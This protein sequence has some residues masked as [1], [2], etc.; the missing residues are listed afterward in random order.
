MKFKVVIPAR[1]ASQRLPGKPLLAIAGRPMIHWVWEA[2]M[3]SGADEVVVA[4]DDQRIM[5]A[6][7]AFGGQALMTSPD[8]PSGTD[9]ISEVIELM[10]WPDDTIVVN[11]Q[12]DEPEMPTDNVF[13]VAELLHHATDAVMAS[14][15][16]PIDAEEDWRNPN[17]VKVVCTQHQRALYFSRAP[18]PWHRDANGFGHSV[19]VAGR[20][21]GLYAYR[22][23][24]VRQYVRLP[25]TPLE[26]LEKLEQLRVLEHGYAIAM[27]PCRKAPPAGVDTE[28]DLHD[29]RQRLEK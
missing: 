11:I 18:M 7:Q 2:A 4:T 24:F 17:V 20:H 25:Q 27:A 23:G 13:Q 16:V 6:V 1:Y 26:Q 28:A 21:I 15:Y 3:K 22:A 10:Q 29:V 5:Q 9:R 19:P 14:L 8:H 12:G